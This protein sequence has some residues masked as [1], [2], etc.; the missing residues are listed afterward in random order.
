MFWRP[1]PGFE[2]SP[3]AYAPAVALMELSRGT[4]AGFVAAGWLRPEAAEDD[5]LRAHTTVISGVISQQLS[6]Q[7]TAGFDDGV[8][9]R[10][11]PLLIDMFFD[12]YAT[13]KDR[14]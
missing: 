8:Y 10:L 14:P 9:T 11:V 13:R 4:L 12:H 1:V 5:A 3:D 6:N 2:P 7:P